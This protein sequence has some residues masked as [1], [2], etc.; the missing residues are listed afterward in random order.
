MERR[1]TEV[2]EKEVDFDR[3]VRREKLD[4]HGL[5]TRRVDWGGERILLWVSSEAQGG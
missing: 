1:W 4:W 5:Y 2:I 3:E